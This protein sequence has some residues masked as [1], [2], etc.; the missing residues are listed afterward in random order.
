MNGAF[1]VACDCLQMVYNNLE[2]NQNLTEHKLD[3]AD[4]VVNL[5]VNKVVDNLNQIC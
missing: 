4:K 2:P 1:N 5:V 3:L